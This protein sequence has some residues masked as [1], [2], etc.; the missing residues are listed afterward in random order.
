MRKSV[1]SPWGCR[2][3]TVDTEV[4]QTG[5]SPSHFSCVV[6]TDPCFS[7]AFPGLTCTV[8]SRACSYFPRIVSEEV[9]KSDR[10]ESVHVAPTTSDDL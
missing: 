7:I 10:Q 2:N 4:R 9:R 8:I 6:Q 5:C 3:P 1:I